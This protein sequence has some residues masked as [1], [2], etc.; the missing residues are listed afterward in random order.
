MGTQPSAKPSAGQ[1]SF[2][3]FLAANNSPA[4][5]TGPNLA[6]EPEPEPEPVAEE[7]E[8]EDDVLEISMD[9]GSV[10][11]GSQFSISGGGTPTA[12]GG[13]PRSAT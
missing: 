7:E 6:A 5:A 8:E 13:V 3:A 9:D 11:M 10:S 4:S 1:G 2:A 12:A